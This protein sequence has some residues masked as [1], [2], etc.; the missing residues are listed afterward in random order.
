[1]VGK[2]ITIASAGIEVS[3][4]ESPPQLAVKAAVD[5]G[6]SMHYHQSKAISLDQCRKADM[7]LVMEVWQLKRVRSKF[8]QYSDRV[9]LLSQFD[10]N[11][12]QNE[13]G[14]NK[15]NIMDPYGKGDIEFNRCFKRIK[16]CIDTLFEQ[17]T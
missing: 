17:V 8:P 7:I 13:R 1:M 14:W 15:Y 3:R 2:G 16:I 6:I 5:F 12:F 11:D 10:R 9:Y 4:S